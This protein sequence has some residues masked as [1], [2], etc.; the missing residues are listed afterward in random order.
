ML[1]IPKCLLKDKRK[2]RTAVVF[3]LKTSCSWKHARKRIL[4]VK[5]K[6]ET[7]YA[8]AADNATPHHPTQGIPA[9]SPFI[10]FA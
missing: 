5:I 7:G 6:I 4:R 10:G 2:Q 3:L 9:V 8:R 1:V